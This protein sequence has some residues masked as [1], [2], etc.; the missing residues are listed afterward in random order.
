VNTSGRKAPATSRWP[1]PS[2]GPGARRQAAPAV[3]TPRPQSESAVRR[4]RRTLLVPD[5]KP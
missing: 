4:H 5:E 3:A 1:T 2:D